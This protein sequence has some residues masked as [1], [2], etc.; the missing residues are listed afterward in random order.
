MKK[1]F[2]LSMTGALL[3]TPV[4]AAQRCINNNWDHCN[5]Y[6]EDGDSYTG[7]LWNVAS[8]VDNCPSVVGGVAVMTTNYSMEGLYNA[9]PNEYIY[10]QSYQGMVDNAICVCKMTRPYTGKYF[11]VP[12]PKVGVNTSETYC[13]RNCAQ[14]FMQDETFRNLILATYN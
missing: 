14:S 2:I 13:A 6:Y 5:F 9:L 12:H 10:D 7:M 4:T 3:A 1:I 8:D 11:V